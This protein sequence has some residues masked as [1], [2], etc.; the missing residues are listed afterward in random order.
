MLSGRI[1]A[2]RARQIPSLPTRLLL[3]LCI[4]LGWR[5]ENAVAVGSDVVNQGHPPADDL[6]LLWNAT[7]ELD[8][9]MR[10][11]MSAGNS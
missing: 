11:Q 8:Q 9:S 5:F 10:R 3:V 4:Y 2:E 1:F 7:L 6:H